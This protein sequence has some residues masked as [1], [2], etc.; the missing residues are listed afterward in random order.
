MLLADGSQVRGE[1]LSSES[2]AKFPQ[3]WS[4]YS[5]LN[6]L[7]S[8]I[9]KSKI[10]EHIIALQEGKSQDEI[11]YVMRTSQVV[12]H[13]KQIFQRDCRRVRHKATLPYA[14][15]LQHHWSSPRSQSARRFH[16]RA[17]GDGEC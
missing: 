14:W 5:V 16:S 11:A 3:V 6:V 13:A 1:T 15:I 10:N 2:E 17:E 9:Q 7:Y 12:W 8:L 4:A